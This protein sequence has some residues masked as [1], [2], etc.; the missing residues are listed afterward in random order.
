MNT[1]KLLG[2]ALM[3]IITIL[4]TATNGI[5][6]TN[7]N[8]KLTI[9]EEEFNLLTKH[10]EKHGF[11]IDQGDKQVTFIDS[12]GT[13]HAFVTIKKDTAGKRSNNAKVFQISVWAYENGIRDQEHF[14]GY[15]I[16][17]DEVGLISPQKQ[18]SQYKSKIQL[19]ISELLAKARKTP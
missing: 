6:Q 10:I 9:P 7:A 2:F 18:L 13:R 4:L 5:A 19:G 12:K 11:K 3:L 8:E 15:Y 16:R 17:K 1:T 14:F